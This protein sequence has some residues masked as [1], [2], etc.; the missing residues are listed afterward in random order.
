MA[1]NRYKFITDMFKDEDFLVSLC[2]YSN[3][4]INTVIKNISKIIT[5]Y[6]KSEIFIITKDMQDLFN[7]IDSLPLNDDDYIIFPINSFYENNIKFFGL[8]PD[9]NISNL[10][11]LR[12]ISSYVSL[13]PSTETSTTISRSIEDALEKGFNSPNIVYKSILKQPNTKEMPITLGEDEKTYYR[14]ISAERNRNIPKIYTKTGTT[15]SNSI[16]KNII[17][18]DILLVFLPANTELY[19]DEMVSKIKPNRLNYIKL[20]DRYKLIEI[21]SLN[22]G[23]KKGTKI[24][25]KTGELYEE[26]FTENKKY[27]SLSYARPEVLTIDSSFIYEDQDLT[28]DSIYDVDILYNEKNSKDGTSLPT[29]NLSA[30]LQ[31]IR[32]SMDFSLKFRNGIYRFQNGRHRIVY[33]KNYYERNKDFYDSEEYLKNDLKIFALVYRTIEDPVINEKLLLIQNLPGKKIFLKIDVLDDEPKII[34]IYNYYV[35]KT[36]NEEDLYN[37]YK[38]LKNN[39]EKNKYLIGLNI[40]DKKIDYKT[41]FN[42]I[43]IDNERIIFNMNF[44]DILDYLKNNEIIINGIKITL[45]HIDYTVLYSYYVAMIRNIRLEN[46]LGR[47]STVVPLAKEQI[48]TEVIKYVVNNYFIDNKDFQD[49]LIILDNLLTN[50][51]KL[52]NYPKE[53]I[54]KYINDYLYNLEMEQEMKKL[55]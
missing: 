14:K 54:L 48:K 4:D 31:K 41:L 28:G 34:T 40:N 23:Y 8:N 29:P 3:N 5:Y 43:V 6:L 44:S 21:C 22:K 53:D 11:D 10:K 36:N 39:Q 32:T 33:L 37:L 38:Y 46:Y 12:K 35:Y 45:T 49:P 55:R 1:I 19:K 2:N 24:N 17:G 7:K 20:P 15:I 51:P 42:K 13:F 18:K 30:N 16:V 26:K 25:Y 27:S 52:N 9:N 47:T 50:N